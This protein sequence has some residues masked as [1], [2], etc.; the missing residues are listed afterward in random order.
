TWSPDG[1]WIS[2]LDVEDY[3]RNVLAPTGQGRRGVASLKWSNDGSRVAYRP[4]ASGSDAPLYVASSTWNGRR[5]VTR[6]RGSDAV[7]WAPDDS[8]F[9]YEIGRDSCCKSLVVVDADGTHPRRLLRNADVSS[10]SWSPSGR[11]LAVVEADRIYVVPTDGGRPR[12]LAGSW[13]SFPD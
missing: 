3:Y 12:R 10:V 11:L 9:V 6:A 4:R 8:R 13:Q 2:A 5:L 1:R 7:A